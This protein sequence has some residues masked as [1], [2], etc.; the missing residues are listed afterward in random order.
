MTTHQKKVLVIGHKNPDTDSICSAIAYA[1]LR[2]K[3]TGKKHVPR[4][5]GEI[6]AETA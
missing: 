6:N 4:C 5:C 2:E 3:M 1:W